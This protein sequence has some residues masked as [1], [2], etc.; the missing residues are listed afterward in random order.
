MRACLRSR[1]RQRLFVLTVPMFRS[2]PMVCHRAAD[3]RPGM[4]ATAFWVL[5]FSFLL[6]LFCS[7][8]VLSELPFFSGFRLNVA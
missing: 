3:Y 1:L 7:K 8:D 2:A 4:R 6:I 5:V